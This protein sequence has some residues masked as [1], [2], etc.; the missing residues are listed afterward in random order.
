MGQ[1]EI[2]NQLAGDVNFSSD[3]TLKFDLCNPEQFERAYRIALSMPG[4]YQTED[5]YKPTFHQLAEAYRDKDPQQMH[6]ALCRLCIDIL[7]R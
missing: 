3:I 5:Y 6:D 4:C 1:R 7:H 2:M